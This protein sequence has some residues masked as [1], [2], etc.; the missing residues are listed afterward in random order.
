MLGPG[1]RRRRQPRGR[2]GA[3]LHRAQ[4]APARHPARRWV[5]EVCHSW[6]DRFRRL[7]PRWE[8]KASNDLGFV[9]LAACLIVYRKLRHHRLLSG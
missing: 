8:K 2:G 3:G 6:Y 4:P 5:V 9:Q 7:L 1:R